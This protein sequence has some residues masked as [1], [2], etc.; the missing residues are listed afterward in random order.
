MSSAYC[1]GGKASTERVHLIAQVHNTE[2]KR[3][4]KPCIVRTEKVSKALRK[5]LVEWIMK[6]SN[7]YE[8]PIARDTLMITDAESGVRK[9]V[10][11]LLLECSMQQFHNE[12]IESLYYGGLRGSI[13][14]DKNDVIRNELRPKTYHPK[15][16]CGCAICNTSNYSQ[17]LLNAC[18]LRQLKIMKD[19]AD[20][21]RGWE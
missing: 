2:V 11:K 20:N 1:W 12:L 9:R 14:T 16:I 7:M 8:S 6:Y 15:M 5:K 10:P 21:S 3:S 18:W 19:K 13:H 4:I 17:E